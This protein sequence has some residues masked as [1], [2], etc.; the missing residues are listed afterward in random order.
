MKS[1]RQPACDLIDRSRA[2]VVVDEQPVL[3]RGQD[4]GVLEDLE[5]VA[6]GRLGELKQRGELAGQSGPG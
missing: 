1:A 5:V 2:D 6:D 3:L 4:A